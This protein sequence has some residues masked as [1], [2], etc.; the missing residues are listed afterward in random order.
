MRLTLFSLVV[1]TRVDFLK[2]RF[3]FFDFLFNK[4]L[5]KA[6][7]LLIFPVAVNLKRF[8]ALEL[9]FTFGI[10]LNLVCKG[11]IFLF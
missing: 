7:F 8:L 1:C 9:V 2:L 3:L 10:A 5:L 4:W 11:R 6:L